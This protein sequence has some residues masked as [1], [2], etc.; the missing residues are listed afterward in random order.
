MRRRDN[1]RIPTPGSSQGQ[2]SS[3]LC[4]PPMFSLTSVNFN[5]KIK[6]RLRQL[7]VLVGY[8]THNKEVSMA[9]EEV[10]NILFEQ[11]EDIKKIFH[12]NKI[13]VFGS[14]VRNKQTKK[15]DIDILV[16]FEK[17]HKDF[18]NYMRLKYYLETV[19]GVKVD[20]VIKEAVKPGLKERIFNEVIY[21]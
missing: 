15:S 18:F 20:L 10:K 11:R 1:Y 19:L 21:V 9:I 4:L 8:C 17:G 5:G 13:G 12:V 7:P 2:A 3:R 6:N 14:F 16:E